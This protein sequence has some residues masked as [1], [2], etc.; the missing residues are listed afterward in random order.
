MKKNNIIY[1]GILFLT[2]TLAS[3]K[4]DKLD[5]Y[6]FNSIEL[7]QSFK[8]VQ[9]AK[10]WDNGLYAFLRGRVYGAYTFYTDVQ[11]DQLNA[12]LDYGNRN[13]SPHR[14]G[15]SFL[16]DDQTLGPIWQNY[17]NAINN[18]NIAIDG[19]SS[20]P[21]PMASDVSTLNKYKGDAYLLRAYYY[22]QL[23][24]RWAKAYEPSTAATDLGVPLILKYN[25]NLQPARAT[26]KAVY[27]QIL[28]DISQ[29]KTLLAATAGAQGSTRFTKDAAG[30]LEA[31]V[32]LHIQDW[33]G[34]KTAA[35]LVIASNTYPLINNQTDFNSMWTNDLGKEVIFQ[36]QETAP[37]ELGNANN[38][39]LGLIPQSGNY[40]P[41]FIPS[42][43]VVDMYD[44]TDIRKGTYF[45]QKTLTI[46]GSNYPNIYLVTKYPGNP[47]LF[48]GA[49]TNYQQKAK[50]FRVAELYLISAEAG[51]RSGSSGEAA[52]LITLN[53]LRVNRGVLPL[54]GVSGANLF[55][56]VKDERF[57]ELAFEGFR[58]DD[59]KRWH[60]GF[61]RHDPQNLNIL[62]TVGGT[63]TLAI[64][65]DDNKFV[66]GIPANDMTINQSLIG[67]QNPG[68]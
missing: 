25:P 11:A 55:Q 68:W 1:L 37:S 45:G 24:L 64:P 14:W 52:A 47:S 22:D 3:C 49:T 41:D 36:C 28:L 50:V 21:T 59:L 46:Q 12:S 4:K 26:S 30:A 31:R 27:D 7:S 29:A 13:G 23:M 65:A 60:Q 67:Q 66:W 32:R 43:W 54:S 9:D 53:L 33:V 62:N 56:A 18:V 42:Q 10:S 17:Y 15:S 61:Q 8:T 5:R 38:I 63:P 2:I 40:T 39:Y 16:S 20:I 51:V 34:A 48:T 35:D 58:L 44:N 6:P 19:Y 57:R